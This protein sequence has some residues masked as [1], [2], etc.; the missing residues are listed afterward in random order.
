MGLIFDLG[1]HRGLDTKFYLDTGFH[2]IPPE[3]K[4]ILCGQTRNGFSDQ[5]KPGHLAI[6][7]MALAECSGERIKF[8]VNNVKDDW[9][10]AS[11]NWAEKGGHVLVEI[12]VETITLRV[13]TH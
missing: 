11:T 8:Y 2:V 6:I 10:S 7:K 9:S 1:K 4:P 3:A 13:R 12:E 5:L